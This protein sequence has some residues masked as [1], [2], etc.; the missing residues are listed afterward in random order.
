MTMKALNGNNYW[1]SLQIKLRRCDFWNLPFG[2]PNCGQGILDGG[3]YL[4]EGKLNGKYKMAIRNNP[5]NSH[6][7]KHK[8]IMDLLNAIDA[9]T[10][11]G[12]GKSYRLL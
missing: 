10:E 12:G 8:E 7:P 4:F 11:F 9:I 5:F 6:C 3:Y 2:E 1:D